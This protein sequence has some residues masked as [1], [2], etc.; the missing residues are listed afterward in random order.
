VLSG[1]FGARVSV[2]SEGRRYRAA[3]RRPPSEA[4][5]SGWLKA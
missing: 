2:K 4:G 3:V 5:T 1:A